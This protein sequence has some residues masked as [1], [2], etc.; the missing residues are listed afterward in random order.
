MQ[1][2]DRHPRIRLRVK[3]VF[4]HDALKL[5]RAHE[6]DFVVG[7]M[8]VVPDDLQFRPMLVSEVMLATPEDHPLTRHGSV[9]AKET[10]QYPMGRAAF[11]KLHQISV[12]PLCQ[13]T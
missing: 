8:D 9:S 3:N 5:L 6:V 7:T 11:R 1:F 4:S 10:E 2:H 13:A 12:G